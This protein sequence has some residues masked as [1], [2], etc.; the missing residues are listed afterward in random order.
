MIN[1]NWAFSTGCGLDF[2]TTPPT[3]RT[4]NL[5]PRSE[6]CASISDANGNLLFYTNGI[7]VWDASGTEQVNGLLG[8]HSSTQSSI[9]VPV[10]GN[11]KEYYIFTIDGGTNSSPPYNHFN[12]IRI[13]VDTWATQPLTNYMIP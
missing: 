10:P 5:H 7:K 13:H 1:Q 4:S 2:I 6:G 11:S 8:D 9:I 3:V 12:G